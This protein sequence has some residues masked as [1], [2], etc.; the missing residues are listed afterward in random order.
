MGGAMLTGVREAV[1]ALHM[2]KGDNEDDVDVAAGAVDAPVSRKRSRVGSARAAT[3]RPRR[4]GDAV[5]S[6]TSAVAVLQRSL[7][8]ASLGVAW[9]GRL[10]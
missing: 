5:R 10:G 4:V 3:L 7:Q 2:L 1:R 9:C 6:S 8:P